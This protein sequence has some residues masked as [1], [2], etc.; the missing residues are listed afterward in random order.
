MKY[1]GSKSRIVKDILP[2][3]LNRYNGNV[4][5]DLFCGGVL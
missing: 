4:F 2:V 5:V 3:M 1:M